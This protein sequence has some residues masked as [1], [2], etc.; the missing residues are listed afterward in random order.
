MKELE[1]AT[2]VGREAIRFY[3][4]AGLL[5]EPQR[6][7]RNVA[8]YD[9]SFVERI[10]L[11]RELQQKR[12]LPLRVI[13]TIVE[14]D[15]A[16]APAE[17]QT[18]VALDRHLLRAAGIDRQRPPV[19]LAELARRTGV[20]T[21]EIRQLAAVEAIEITTRKRVQCLDEPGVRIVELLAKLRAAGLS[22]AFGFGAENMRLYVDMV[23]WL[24]REELRVFTRGVTG[25]ADLERVSVMA[26]AAIEILNEVIGVLR[27]NV[28]LRSLAQGDVA[29]A[30]RAKARKARKRH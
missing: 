5:P 24:A 30:S 8:W 29:T 28:L 20:P 13:K 1:Q 9:G 6:L 26:E 11:I 15:T 17:V 2:G 18:L 10:R 25:K 27:T 14:G 19:T 3:I 21:R 23:R 7:G 16:L 4:H 12:F 22:E